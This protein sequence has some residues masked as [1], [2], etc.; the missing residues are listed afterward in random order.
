MAF[1][2]VTPQQARLIEKLRREGKG[3]KAIAN[4]TGLSRDTIR[5]F[6]KAHEDAIPDPESDGAARCPSCG[7][8]I[9]QPR[10]GR[11]RR[12]CS[13]ACRHAWWAK[14]PDAHRPSD[15][16]IYHLTCAHCGK[17]FD[18]YGNRSRRYCCRSCYFASRFHPKD[19]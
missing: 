17:P 7:K 3:Y 1:S 15:Q 12:F 11:R 19:I 4:A 10:T 16:A 13:D 14:H 9:Q 6:C 5:Y 8:M 18:S 2:Q